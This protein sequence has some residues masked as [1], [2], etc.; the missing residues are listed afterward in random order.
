MIIRKIRK[1]IAFESKKC[2][3]RPILTGGEC[4]LIEYR[5]KN[6]LSYRDEIVL[7]MVAEQSKEHEKTHIVE[8]NGLRLLKCAAIFG[9]NASGKSN[10]IASFD[11]LFDV[12]TKNDSEP[13]KTLPF[14]KL[15]LDSRN[16]PIRFEITFLVQKIRYRYELEINIDGIIYEA[17]YGAPK[18]YESLYYERVYENIN[19]TGKYFDDKSVL[20]NLKPD[21]QRTFLSILAQK[22]TIGFDWAKQIFKALK[23]N[24]LPLLPDEDFKSLIEHDLIDQHP[25]FDPGL[26]VSML[27]HADIG[28]YDITIKE[29]DEVDEYLEYINGSLDKEDLNCKKTETYFLHNVFNKNSEKTDNIESF[30]IEQESAGTKKLYCLLYPILKILIRGGVL[31]I[32]EIEN[33][34]HTLICQKI[35][36]WFNNE[37]INVGNGQLIF[38]SHN[39]LLMR[40][41]LLRR[42]QI[43]FVEKDQCGASKIFSLYDFNIGKDYNYVNNYLSGR[44]GAI[45]YLKDFY[46]E[47]GVQKS[48]EKDSK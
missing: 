8:I 26:I 28:I 36:S 11:F 16:E 39:L 25:V 29:L 9:A 31:Y 4:M 12:I 2:Y 5:V 7:S 40:P 27:K 37:K 38:T 32:D 46:P 10:L 13:F 20:N 6:F 1:N 23:R 45:P 42:D 43:Y 22:S 24:L 41:E 47:L 34:L 19:K 30:S 14:Y 21:M 48:G 35:I 15:D 18:N 3:H 17:L 33:S 44:F